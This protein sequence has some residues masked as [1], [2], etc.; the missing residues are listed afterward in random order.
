GVSGL[1][2]GASASFNPATLTQPGVST[3]TITSTSNSPSGNYPLTIIGSNGAVILSAAV[4]L[5]INGLI[6]NPGTLLWTAGSADGNWSTALN[7]TNPLAGG[8]GPPGSGNGLVFT[9]LGVAAASALTS[10][11]SSVVI[12]AN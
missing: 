3:L 2:T 5:T 9:N 10:P 6:A 4:T 12:P 11:G 7:W 1:P 8:N